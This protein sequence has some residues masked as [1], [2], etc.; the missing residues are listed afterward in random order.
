VHV[1]KHPFLVALA[2]GGAGLIGSGAVLAV[3]FDYD[4]RRPA[5]LRACDEPRT[6]GRMDQARTCYQRILR[7]SRD[8]SS[9]A[10]AAWALGDV[11]QAN[12]LFRAAVQA[13]EK[14]VR[15]RARW[16]RLYLETHQYG[17]AADLFRE[18]LEIDGSDAQATLGMARLLSEQ[19]DGEA[20]K[21]VGEVIGKS[22]ERDRVQAHALIEALLISARMDLDD[23]KHADA[24]KSLERALRIAEAQKLPPLEAYALLAGL[25]LMRGDE[26]APRWIERSLAYNPRF[27][28]VYETLA[29]YEIM[30]RRYREASA[31]LEKAVETEPDRWSAQAEYGVNLLRLGEVDASQKALEKAYSGDPFSATTV[32]TLRVLDKLKTFSVTRTSSPDIVTWLD[33]KEADALRPYVEEVARQSLETFGKRY[34]FQPQQPVTIELYPNH[35]DFAVRTAGLP[36]IG[37]LG[38][39]FGH[40]V[41][42]DSPSGRRAGDFHWGS[43]LWHEMAH[44]VTLSVTDH[45]VPRWLSEGISVFEEWRTG[46]TP[47]IAVSPRALDVFRDGKFIGVAQLDEG[48]I[49][50]AYEDQVQVSY[51]QAGLTCY[52]IEQKHGFDKLVALLHQFKKDTN[53]AAAIEA[54]FRMSPREFDKDFTAFMHER[55]ASILKD[56][57][58]WQSAMSAAF[59]A[60]NRKDWAAAIE[61]SRKAIGIFPDYTLDGSAYLVLANA[62]NQTGKRA[63]AIKALQDYR[64]LGGWN[65]TALRQLA[66]WLEEAQNPQEAAEIHYALVLIEPLDST[67]HSRLAERYAATGKPAES[68]RE[69]KVLLALNPHDTASANFGIARALHS[70]GNRAESRRHLLEALETAPHFRPA[71]DLLLE[72][73]GKPNP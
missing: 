56:P 50:P 49:R 65:P 29:H 47:G 51:M 3:D 69:Y 28:G 40:L 58:G 26:K 55:F 9:Q 52:F 1:R 21:V 66:T 41:A 12:E 64:R 73:S 19:F 45:R 31:W 38:V 63:D 57:K 16:G 35:D 60:E 7:S 33:R 6:R 46:P 23:G 48:F 30:R 42:M 43:T 44:V 39:T 71:Q 11:R 4:P 2:L 22:S 67:L 10:E 25:D 59:E 5:E 36:G 14:A 34:G 8:S 68:L 15:P 18:A 72:L 54:T 61:H 37:L 13:D 20:R 53:T 32:N 24:Q 27:G 17:D 62:L 70:L